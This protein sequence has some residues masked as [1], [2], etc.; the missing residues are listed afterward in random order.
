MTFNGWLL[1]AAVAALV[2]A[3]ARPMGAWLFALYDGRAA[4]GGAVER[5]F[6]RL[7]GIDPA[8]DMSWRRYAVH[9]LIFSFAGVLLT[10]AF[11]RVQGALPLNPLGLKA[12]DPHLAMNTAISFVTN[13]NWQ[14]YSGESTMSNFSQ[15]VALTVHNFLS[16]ATGI[17]VA[18]AVI[19]GFARAR[20]DWRSA[21]SGPT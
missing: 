3:M 21:T 15:M 12:L 19:R 1:I 7:A 6:Y 5:G 13:T 4:P 20:S 11:L 10:Y 8:E 2:V 9:V 14:S 17:A 18:F 16:A